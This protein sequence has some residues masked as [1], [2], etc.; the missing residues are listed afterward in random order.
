[1]RK[2]FIYKA[3]SVWMIAGM[4]A[5]A[6]MHAQFMDYG[7]DPSRL[8]WNRAKLEH[9]TLIYPRGMDSMAYRYALHLENAYPHLLKTMGTPVKGSFPVVLHP[10]NMLSNGMVSWSPRRMELLTTPSYSQQ[11]ESWDRHLALHESRHVIQTGKLQTGFF[12]PLYY[13]IGE[14]SAGI[15]SLF[16]PRWFFEG[17]AVGIETAMSDA[18]RGRL[19][20]FQMTYRAQALSGDSFYSFDKWYLGS[21]KDYTGDYY[22]LGYDL[23]S[24]ARLEYG[25]DIWKKTTDR[26]VASPIAFPPL[27][28]AFRHHTGIGFDRLFSE[29]FA[30]LRK[31]WESRD[32]VSVT[33]YYYHTP[34]T[35][36]Y[37]SYK[38][39]QTWNDSTVIAVKSSLS[40]I[41]SLVSLTGRDER[42][43]TYIGALRSRIVVDNNCVYWIENVSGIRWEHENHSALKYYDLIDG[44]LT[45]LA[46][47]R[48]YISF[49]VGDSTIAAS[50]FTE[51]GES[52]I[53]LM[54][55]ESGKEYRQYP[56]PGNA[57]IK[58]LAMGGQDTVYA[59]ATGDRGIS[60]LQLDTHTGEWEELM[61]PTVANITSPF[62]REGN[63][64]FE[65][66]LNGI[67]NIYR[68]SIPD[69][70]AYRLTSARFGAFQPTV[71]AD[72][73][74]LLFADYQA[75]GY[76]IARLP[77]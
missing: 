2:M 21:Y 6:A 5:P 57:F 67:N 22:A 58:D 28:K 38:Y 13:L 26:Y 62:F 68:L 7:A 12:H 53:V 31:E 49:A 30:F 66:G 10:A 35:K 60:L 42:R 45:T 39:P 64:Y 15:S 32:T 74:A 55:R 20:E 41:P 3:I 77:L 52:C 23:I 56:T 47:H 14:Q 17:D 16:A 24:F 8:K 59:V 25:A 73:D 34:E 46:S 37:T 29:T 76:R 75:K 72:G 9:Y 44:R 33:P 4:F 54:N 40:D 51:E 65:S 48:R 69:G 19:P 11:A 61:K 71:S 43:L 50:L 63:L 70:K 27:S 1:M 18:G 36:Q